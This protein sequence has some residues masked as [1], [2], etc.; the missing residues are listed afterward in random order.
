MVNVLLG[1]H[2]GGMRMLGRVGFMRMPL[3]RAGGRSFGMPVSVPAHFEVSRDAELVFDRA[4]ACFSTIGQGSF[5]NLRSFDP[6]T[7]GMTSGT[8]CGFSYE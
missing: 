2:L 7:G 8:V 1:L 4:L 5:S 3:V 6:M